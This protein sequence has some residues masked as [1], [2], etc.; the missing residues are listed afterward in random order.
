MSIT[1]D[2]AAQA[3]GE[4]EGA[5]GRVRRFGLYADAAPYFMLWGGIW[6]VADIATQFAPRAWLIWPVLSLAGVVI[7]TALGVAQQKGRAGSRV[8]ERWR[9]LATWLTVIAFI[10]T[11]GFVLRPWS[12]RQGHSVFGLVFGFIYLVTGFWIGRRLVILGVALI[13]LTLL[14]YYA[15]HAWYPLFMGVVGGGALILG[16][17]W[18]RSI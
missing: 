15:V 8:I 5:A 7:A 17:L 1:R 12:W 9:P 13:A 10:V 4:I 16:G 3:L 11:L 2:E 18:L 14:G 6:L